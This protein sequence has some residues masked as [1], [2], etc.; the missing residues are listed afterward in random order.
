MPRYVYDEYRLTL[1]PRTDGGYD[2]IGRAADGSEQRGTFHLPLTG[3]ALEEAV[4]AVA[5]QALRSGR[6]VGGAAP[7]TFDPEALGRA[8]S[9]ALLTGAVGAGYDAARAAATSSGRG[10]RLALSLGATPALLSVPWELLYRPPT[11]LANQRQTPVVR[12]L[13]VGRVPDP[14]AIEGAIR[15]LGVIAN[16]PDTAPLDVAGERERVERAVAAMVSAGA[17]VVD[18]LAPATPRR[19]REALRD[20]TY[21]VLHYVGHGDFTPSGDGVLYLEDDD[22]SGHTE[23]DSGELASLLAD[24]T[25]LRLVVLNACDGARTSLTDPFAGVATTLVQLGVPAVIAMQF[26]ISDAAAILFA[27]ELYTNLIGG[28]APVDAAVSEAR[29]AIF[30]EQGTMEWATPVLFLADTEVQLFDFVEPPT[31]AP[32]PAPSDRPAR[33]RNPALVGLGLLTA[34][35]VLVVILWAVTRSGDPSK[36]A[37]AVTSVVTT[38]ATT[39]T[40]GSPPTSTGPVVPLTAP[41][42]FQGTIPT[43]DSEQRHEFSATA[44]QQ[45]YVAAAEPCNPGLRYE[46]HGPSDELVSGFGHRAC[47]ATDRFPAVADGTYT[48]VVSS[49]G[50]TGP[51]DL[52]V[53]PIRADRIAPG[54]IGQPAA[55]TIDELGAT[56]IYTY[57]LRAGDLLYL[58]GLGVCAQTATSK[59]QLGNAS[60][61]PLL[62]FDV[63]SCQDWGRVAIPADGRYDLVVHSASGGTGPYSI[64]V[65]AIRPDGG[66][67]VASGEAATGTIDVAGAVDRWTFEAPVGATVAITPQLECVDGLRFDVFPPGTESTEIGFAR[68]TCEVPDPFV[69][70]SGGSHTIVVDATGAAST[71]PATGAYSLLVTITPPA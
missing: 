47:E 4:V 13:D 22:G 64:L 19:L 69:V 48:V 16:P 44:G 59:Y 62:G 15:I 67:V 11:F 45:L 33:R 38:S 49:N 68:Q 34:A 30:V 37:G 26:A 66:G 25:A 58:D 12:H 10:L 52:T 17:V 60:G 63:D 46:V 39:T 28:R 57:D 20:G 3:G 70:S 7:P 2:A 43:A 1:T 9:A 6:D 8:L 29:K 54:V 65:T 14:P 27:E 61:D 71:G 55:G 36:D 53:R 24:Q 51:Y 42:T 32:P 5:A 21:H 18:W 56:D 35:V 40:S 31:P 50:V 23:L 41:M